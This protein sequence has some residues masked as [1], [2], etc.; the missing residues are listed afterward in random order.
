MNVWNRYQRLQQIQQLNPITDHSLI[1]RLVAGYEF[2]WD[3][4][5]ALELAMVKTFCVPSI[6]RLLTRT[7]EF[8]HHTQKRYDDTGLLIAEILQWGYDNCLF[9]SN[10]CREYVRNPTPKGGGPE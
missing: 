5:R 8:H 10:G 2:P 4:T 6:S 3:I 7:G 1:C 9:L